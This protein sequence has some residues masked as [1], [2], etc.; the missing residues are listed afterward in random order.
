MDVASQV[1]TGVGV[2]V[3][4]GLAALFMRALWRYQHEGPW[5]VIAYQEQLIT[6]LRAEIA[7]L[8]AEIE[9]LRAEIE[10]LQ[11]RIRER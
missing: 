7:R 10:S 2:S 4:V 6:E 8:R 3:V 1:W 9:S 11:A 5:R